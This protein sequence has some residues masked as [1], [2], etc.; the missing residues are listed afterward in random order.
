MVKD[1]LAAFQD[2][3]DAYNQC[4]RRK[5]I[6]NFFKDMSSPV[7][8]WFVFFSTAALTLSSFLAG[9]P[10]IIDG[11]GG[12]KDIL[13]SVIGIMAG[14][15]IFYGYLLNKHGVAKE[16]TYPYRRLLTQTFY[17]HERYFMFRGKINAK[18]DRK[19][20]SLEKVKELT[21]SRLQQN[22]GLGGFRVWLL[23]V[24]ASVIVAIIYSLVPSDTSEKLVYIIVVSFYLLFSLLFIYV[25]YDPY[26]NKNNKYRELLLFITIYESD[27]V[28]ENRT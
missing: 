22:Q 6:A 24:C 26:W 9:I 1:D 25:I 19:F 4:S 13:F 3:C 7:F 17:Q 20:P 5:A 2:V 8:Y 21:Q 10:F 28:I 27:S 16:K 14:V 18:F 15:A 11:G 23:G 12:N